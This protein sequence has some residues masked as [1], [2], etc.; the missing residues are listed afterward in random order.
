MNLGAKDRQVL[1][2][3]VRE[4][5]EGGSSSLL[6]SIHYYIREHLKDVLSKLCKSMC[7]VCYVD[8]YPLH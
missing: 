8:Y 3:L 2:Q 6:M 5:G 7:C 4:Y 1:E